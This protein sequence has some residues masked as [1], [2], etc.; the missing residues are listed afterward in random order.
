MKHE[1]V[2]NGPLV[3]TYDVYGDF[4]R[5]RGGIYQYNG[6]DSK[7]GG[8]AVTL[9]GYGTENGIPYWRCQNSWGAKWGESGFFRIRRGFN[10]AGIESPGA[11]SFGMP[12]LKRL[13]SNSCVHGS[14]DSTCKCNCT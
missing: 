6:K 1:L 11:F 10:D 4:S 14:Q 5:Y 2:T 3:A 9:V 12:D 8:H 7:R 13:C